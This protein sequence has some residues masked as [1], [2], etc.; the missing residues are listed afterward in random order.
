M[1]IAEHL[2][3][4]RAKHRTAGDIEVESWMEYHR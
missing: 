1:S 3:E 4:W 2:A